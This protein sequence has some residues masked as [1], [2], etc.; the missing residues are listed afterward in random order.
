M[1]NDKTWETGIRCKKK[2]AQIQKKYRYMD[3]G[4]SQSLKVFPF[5][6]LSM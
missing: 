6:L 3:G 2:I 4:D 1:L 5:F